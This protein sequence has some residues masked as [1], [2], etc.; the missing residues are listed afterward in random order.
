MKVTSP[1][2]TLTIEETNSFFGITNY[3][4]TLIKKE[5]DTSIQTYKQ[6]IDELLEASGN[7]Q[8]NETLGIPLEYNTSILPKERL[9]DLFIQRIEEYQKKV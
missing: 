2:K 6:S 1:L 5:F 7:K 9:F 8:V 3:Q 4:N